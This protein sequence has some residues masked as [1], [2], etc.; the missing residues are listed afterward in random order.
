MKHRLVESS[1]ILSIGYDRE[2]KELFVRFISGKSYIY[3]DV[4]LQ[5]YEE[6]L[7]AGSKGTYFNL[8]IRDR[9]TFDE[10]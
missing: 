10:I 8:H 2:R 4:P 6:L 5:V 7:A 1:A 9:Y 3:H